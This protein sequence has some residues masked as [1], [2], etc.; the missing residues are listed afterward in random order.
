MAVSLEVRGADELRKAARQLRR[1]ATTHMTRE[2][3]GAVKST[4]DQLL[5]PLLKA[6][7][8]AHLPSGYAPLMAADLRVTTRTRLGANI[9]VTARIFARGE[10]ELRDA[11]R[12]DK[13]ALRHPVFGR[14]RTVRAAEGESS[15]GFRRRP[16]PWVTQRVTPGFV[17]RP[18]AA[19]R[20]PLVARIDTSLSRLADRFNSGGAGL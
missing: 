20:A 4:V 19:L 17:D 13:G 10:A 1:I 6:S 8:L 3:R 14:S 11:A 9:G 2:I 7:A 18:A 5:P 15:T 16:N 12:I